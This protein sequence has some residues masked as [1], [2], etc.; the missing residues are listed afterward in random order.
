MLTRRSFLT[1]A[2]CATGTGLF[3]FAPGQ[4]SA[5]DT[6]PKL[7]TY[8]ADKAVDRETVLQWEARRLQVAANRLSGNLPAALVGELD[9]LISR[10]ALS[11]TNIVRERDLLADAKML[12]GETE[13]RDLMAAD[14]AISDP[15]SEA[16]A[17]TGEWAVSSAGLSCTVGAAD[18]FVEWF[19]TR[20]DQNDQRA[21]LIAGP[22]HYVIHTPR[23][24]IQEVIEVTGGA[25]LATRLI[26]D[27]ADN[28]AVPIN[29]DPAFPHETSGWART[30]GGIRIGAVRHQFRDDPG[31]GF[32]AKLAVAFPAPLPPWMFSEHS[33]HLACE[34]SNWVST[35]VASTKP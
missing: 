34:F 19:N 25:V 23:S 8:I 16:A 3:S 32:S 22:D 17:A 15:V 12:M 5:A 7:T 33:W 13:L 1:T 11:T 35:Y 24:G 27:Y 14:I 4:A 6:S 18:G 20:R 10:P 21:M 30:A 2:A 31:G 9:C 26:I 28:A 29:R